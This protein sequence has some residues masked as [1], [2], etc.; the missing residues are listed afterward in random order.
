MVC[1]CTSINFHASVMRIGGAL[2]ALD[3]FGRS[4]EV[5]FFEFVIIKWLT[6]MHLSVP[7]FG[8]FCT[9]GLPVCDQNQDG[10]FWR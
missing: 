3:N 8:I 10:H 2:F 6:L 1:I 7:L 5:G 9:L 4:S